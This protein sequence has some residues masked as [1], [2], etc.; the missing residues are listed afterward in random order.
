ME[1]AKLSPAD[2]ARLRQ[3]CYQRE[4]PNVFIPI[5]NDE[6]DENGYPRNHRGDPVELHEHPV[7]GLTSDKPG[8][9]VGPEVLRC[10]NAACRGCVIPI[11]SSTAIGAGPC[12]MC[13]LFVCEGP[14]KGYGHDGPFIMWNGEQCDGRPEIPDHLRGRARQDLMIKRTELKLY[15]LR[16]MAWECDRI[17][18]IWSPDLKDELERDCGRLTIVYQTSINANKRRLEVELAEN[19]RI[20]E[21]LP[22]DYS[23]GPSSSSSNVDWN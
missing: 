20:M 1:F 8:C 21:G 5:E 15:V 2:V 23:E 11:W 19:R 6:V 14:C 13:N 10:P 22:D 18:E 9:P 16:L 17:V 3:K 7:W 4:T 12:L